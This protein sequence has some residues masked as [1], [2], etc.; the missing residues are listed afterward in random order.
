MQ[1]QMTA[2]IPCE[3]RSRLEREYQEVCGAFDRARREL[4]AKIGVLPKKEYAAL[5][6]EAELAWDA[7][8]KSHTAL[9]RHLRQH[10]CLP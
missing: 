3:E 8:Q 6:R 9:D 1:H 5:S 7:L 2:A 10:S 4:Q